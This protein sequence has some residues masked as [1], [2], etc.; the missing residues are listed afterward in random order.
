M[1]KRAAF[2][3]GSAPTRV[4]KFVFSR[5]GGAGLYL[6]DS[7]GRNLRRASHPLRRRLFKRLLVVA[8][9]FELDD[10]PVLEQQLRLGPLARLP[11]QLDRL[12]LRGN[13]SG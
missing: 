12:V 3:D 8:R 2:A 13:A 7:N 1:P 5:D 10:L 6:I 9:I 4:T 11:L